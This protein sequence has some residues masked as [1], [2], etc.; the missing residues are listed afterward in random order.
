M[1]W[2]DYIELENVKAT[3]GSFKI[4]DELDVLDYQPVCEFS[5][6]VQNYLKLKHILDD[7]NKM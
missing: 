5:K 7:S 4:F 1:E 6:I 2:Y 3:F